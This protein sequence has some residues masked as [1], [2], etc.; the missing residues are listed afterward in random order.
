LK[1]VVDE[2]A[3]ALG[4]SGSLQRQRNQAAQPAFRECVLA[5]EQ[6]VI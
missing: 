1:A 5:G 2:H 6:P 3:V 4:P